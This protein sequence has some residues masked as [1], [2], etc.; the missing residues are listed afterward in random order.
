[1]VVFKRTTITCDDL[2]QADAIKLADLVEKEVNT[3][4][5]PATTG[6]TKAV[7]ELVAFDKLALYS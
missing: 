6:L 4:M 3:A 1:L 5:P 7:R 2:L